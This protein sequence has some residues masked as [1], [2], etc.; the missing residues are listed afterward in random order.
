MLVIRKNCNKDEVTD[1]EFNQNGCE[2]LIKNFTSGDVYVSLDETFNK[3]KAIKLPTNTYQIVAYKYDKRDF[4]TKTVKVQAETAGE[5]E[6]QMT[7]W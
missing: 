2:F 4:M 7:L 5:V 6:V 1:F 3:D